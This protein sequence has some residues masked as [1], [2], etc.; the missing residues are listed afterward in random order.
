MPVDLGAFSQNI[1][2]DLPD[3]STMPL[4]QPDPHP[5]II[6]EEELEMVRCQCTNLSKIG[7]TPIS[8]I[9]NEKN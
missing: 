3:L 7:H 5:E 2:F 9:E 6:D 1:P 4:K 8:I